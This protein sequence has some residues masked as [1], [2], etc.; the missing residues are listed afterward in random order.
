MS[1]SIFGGESAAQ[2]DSDG[3]AGGSGGPITWTGPG[4]F[5]QPA[6]F[7]AKTGSAAPLLAGFS[8]AL[9]GVVAQAPSSFR[10]PGATLTVLT[11]VVIILVAC[12]QFGFRGRAVLYSKSD[13]QAWGPLS[14]L[15]PA[16]D[17]RLR[18]HVQARDMAEWR[19]W[20]RRSRLTFNL[21]IVV[22]GVGLALLLAPPLKYSPDQALTTSEAVCRWIGSGV[23]ILG[24][25]LELVWIAYDEVAAGFTRRGEERRGQ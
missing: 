12:V 16:A 13:V 3:R 2:A 7:D 23:A 17:E 1:Q 6:A 21:G 5:G 8:L 9:L 18:A 20:H 15:G 19:R 10:W 22:L 25:L 24:T 11:V 4:D 14:A